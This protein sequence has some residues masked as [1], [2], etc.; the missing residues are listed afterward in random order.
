MAVTLLIMGFSH[1]ALAQ[2]EGG[3]SLTIGPGALLEDSSTGLMHQVQIQ[4]QESSSP[5]IGSAALLLQGGG[6]RV[7]TV[8]AGGNLTLGQPVPTPICATAGNQA[9]RIDKCRAT[10]E[11]HGS[12]HAD[13]PH[14]VYL[15]GATI[16]IAFTRTAASPNSDGE[17]EITVHTAK[18]AIRLKGKVTGAVT[19]PTCNF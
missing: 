16:D 1:M 8:Q 15:G 9:V 6:L 14:T 12:V 17:L 18:Q 11:A 19:M 13:Y 2:H 4:A 5:G 7:C 3:G 10:I